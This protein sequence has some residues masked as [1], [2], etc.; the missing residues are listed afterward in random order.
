MPPVS[1]S[2]NGE[3]SGAR[4]MAYRPAKLS[5][6]CGPPDQADERRRQERA[7]GHIAAFAQ[8][9]ADLQRN[10]DDGTRPMP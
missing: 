3:R 2:L 9:A 10:A 5:T 4:F 7:E 6:A 8:L 1:P